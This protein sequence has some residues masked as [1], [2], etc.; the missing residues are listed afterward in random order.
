MQEV[1]EGQVWADCDTRACG[2]T[3]KVIHVLADDVIVEVLTDA[4]VSRRSSVGHRR[5]IR[6]GRFKPTSTG[7]RLIKEAV[8]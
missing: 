6:L 8:N 5:R 2:R 1:K 7:Y 3:I 4:Q